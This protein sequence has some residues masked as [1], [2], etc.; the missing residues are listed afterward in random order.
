MWFV[1]NFK[2][3]G[4]LVAILGAVWLLEVFAPNEVDMEAAGVTAGDTQ[5]LAP[6]EI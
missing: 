1:F 2:T 5:K 6:T 4:F 3:K